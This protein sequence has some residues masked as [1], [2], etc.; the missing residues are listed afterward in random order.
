MVR[1]KQSKLE[2]ELAEFREVRFSHNSAEEFFRAKGIPLSNYDSIYLSVAYVDVDDADKKLY[3]T[4]L[5]LA[6]VA[7][8]RNCKY[9]TN[10]D[11]CTNCIAGTG[12]RLKRQV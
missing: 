6:D 4:E 10:I 12:L 9:V 7:I 2:A 11:Y 1:K 3:K 5:K 8:K